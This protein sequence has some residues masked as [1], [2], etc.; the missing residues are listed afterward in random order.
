MISDHMTES[1][2]VQTMTETNTNGD[3]IR[4][5]A[6]DTTVGTAGVILAHSRQLT[7]NEIAAFSKRGVVTT[8]RLYTLSSGLTEKH[9]LSDPSGDKWNVTGINNPHGFGYWYEVDL[10]RSDVEREADT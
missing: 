3:I 6:T 8:H 5:F 7:S 2:T 10:S 9:R 4:T 1:W